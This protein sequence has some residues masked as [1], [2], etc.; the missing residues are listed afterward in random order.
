MAYLQNANIIH[1]DLATRNILVDNS[2]KSVKISDFGLA[3]KA[4]ENGY[5]FGHTDRMIPVRWYPIE[6]IFGNTF[7]L[8]S[9]VWSY[10]VTLY[11]MFSHGE[12]PYENEPNLTAD[13]LL[14]RL[15]NGER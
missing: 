13:D 8:A 14:Y 1:R 4:N 9:D 7:T 5:Y 6:S 11:E 2:K 15:Q 10:G 3:Q 12:R